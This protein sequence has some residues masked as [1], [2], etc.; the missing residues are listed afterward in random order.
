[1]NGK[2]YYNSG[3]GK[4]KAYSVERNAQIIIAL[5]KANN[6]RKVI[7]S[8]GATNVT[9]VGSIQ[10]DPYFE[11][12]SCVDERSAAY[13]ACG[14][15]ESSGEP[16][17]LSCT[18]ATSSREYLP[19]L[20][21]AF[22]KN[23]PILV[24]TSSQPNCR[25]GHLTA[26]VTD[27]RTTLNEAVLSSFQMVFIK[28]KE[29][30]FEDT[31]NA[32]KALILLRKEKKPV[33]IN[34][35]THSHKDFSVKVL[36][37]VRKIEYYTDKT[38]DIPNI[39]KGKIGIFIGAHIKFS[40]E[41]TKVIDDFCKLYD[42]AVFCDHT[43]GYYGSFRVQESLILSQQNWLSQAAGLSLLIHIGEITGDYFC[44]EL[45][46][47]E[48]WRVSEDGEV[49][50]YFRKLT[51]VFHMSEIVFFENY[52]KRKGNSPSKECSFAKKCQE[53][54]TSL[55][56][57]IPVLPFGNIWIAQRLSQKLPKNSVIHF[58]ILNSLRSW[59]F[60][61][62]PNGVESSCNVGGFGIDGCVSTLIG[63]S[64]INPD[65]IYFGVIGDLAF[66]Y[67]LN[68]FTSGVAKN[69]VRLL[70]VNNSRGTE[71]RLYKHI[72]A[73]FGN[74]A[75]KYM[76]A[77]GHNG[78]K[79]LTLLK[80][81]SANLGI[82]YLSASSKEEFLSVEEMFISKEPLDKPVILEV[83]VDSFDES[84]AMETITSFMKDKRLLRKRRVRELLKKVGLYY[85][86]S[87]L[88]N[89]K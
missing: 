11:I 10:N 42:A 37:K 56:S 29:D 33:H 75:D 45:M 36:P 44:S 5:L 66:F 9:F 68:A 73:I 85:I 4:V 70:V 88:T 13:M 74:D 21:E 8:P 26:Q 50:D 17:V 81:L 22:K 49:R 38:N 19:A 63:A 72:A 18:G 71:F 57:Q 25:I 65:K 51:K 55:M 52:I 79:S 69:N 43:S 82:N 24:I 83:F 2:S 20:S 30:E 89:K 3:D 39:P 62:L 84:E 31:I 87:S 47:K 86:I 48:V 41:Q 46:P 59:N 15:C 76:A 54:V 67:D 60:F 7:A 78:N 12:Y 61:T 27:R 32:N 16:V 14:L 58:G 1:M 77:A 64:L 40:K 28:D 23:L 80:D 34:L 6:I 35:I 53:E